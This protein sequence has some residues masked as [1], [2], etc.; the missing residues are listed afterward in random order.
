M[1]LHAFYIENENLFMV[2]HYT[3]NQG[4]EIYEV[5]RVINGV[6][7]FLDD[8]LKRFYHSAWLLHLQI[9]LTEAEV[10]NALNHL[11]KSNGIEEGNI[12]F[13]YCFRPYG[14]FQAYFIPH[15]YPTPEM[16]AAGVNCGLYHA[17]RNDPNV[18]AVQAGIRHNAD[19]LMTENK[20]YEVFLVNES[21][22]ITEGSRS[23]VFFVQDNS[24]ITAPDQDILPGITRDK[25]IEIASCTGIQVRYESLQVEQLN[26]IDALFLT[27]TSPKVLPVKRVGEREFS[28]G[29]SVV[30]LLVKE[31]DR[32]IERYIA[33]I[34]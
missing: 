7:L 2:E 14:R 8:H 4:I 11:I 6:P 30:S 18:K 16:V 25:V 34:R 31:F 15:F 28:V 21:G 23:N 26:Q 32:M 17:H 10:Y 13:S 20:W 19:K 22:R 5:V 29:Y 33:S 9:P 27:G 12:R 1:L 24:L 3:P